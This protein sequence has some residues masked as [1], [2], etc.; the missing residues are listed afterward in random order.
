VELKCQQLSGK[1][2]AINE[3]L[4]ISEDWASDI[5]DHDPA[6]EDGQW[7]ERRSR[8]T[9][10]TVKPGNSTKAEQVDMPAW[11]SNELV[12]SKETI[13]ATRTPKGIAMTATR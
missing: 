1:N 8:K 3:T 13:P 7:P 6:T 5:G 4:Y 12:T 2:D 9:E 10:P 11:K